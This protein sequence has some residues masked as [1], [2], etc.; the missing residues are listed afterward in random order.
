[1]KQFITYRNI[2]LILAIVLLNACVTPIEIETRT[3]KDV[4][5]IDA[6]ITNEEKFQEIHLTRSYRFE[7]ENAPRES[8]ARVEVVIDDNTPI[9]FLESVKGTYVSE[10]S[11]AAASGHTYRLQITTSDGNK[12]ISK[13]EELTPVTRIDNLRV[14]SEADNLGTNGFAIKVNSFD[15]NGNSKFYRYEY[16]ETYKII[17]P[18]WSPID[19]VVVNNRYLVKQPKTREERICYGT[20]TSKAIIQTETTGLV[21]DRVAD[22]TVRFIPITDPIVT[23]RYSILVKQYVQSLEAYNYYKTLN[24]LSGNDNIFSQTQPGFFYGNIL[25]EGNR[26]EKVIGYFEVTSVSEKRIFFNFTD[27][28]PEE[29]QPPYFVPCDIFAPS[30]TAPP[31]DV[32][33]LVEM[34]KNKEV[35][36][37]QD[38][39]NYPNPDDKNEGKYNVVQTA[40][41]DCTVL[42]S[43]VKPDFWED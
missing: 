1:M 8:G 35:K 3:F 22:F 13:K 38:N 23:H 27:F 31:G 7:E 37:Y 39:P 10:R 33:P 42:G 16:E 36:Y 18:L 11:F 32:S 30:T 19:L 12:Y 6:T 9:R 40:C 25:P 21:E 15:P 24:K 34:I 2:F 29:N 20:K 17:A 28:Y 26:D 14:T 43:N 4:L 41:G 5:V